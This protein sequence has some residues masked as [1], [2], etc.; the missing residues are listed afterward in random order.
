MSIACTYKS[1]SYL[2]FAEAGCTKDR[3]EDLR[4]FSFFFRITL[5]VL[6]MYRCTV[7]LKEEVLC[8]GL[9]ISCREESSEAT[10]SVRT[11]QIISNNIAL[12]FKCPTFLCCFGLVSSC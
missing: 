1:L 8:C 12:S 6:Y 4:S 3:G 9:T 5:E 2:I 10:T 7:D 11:E